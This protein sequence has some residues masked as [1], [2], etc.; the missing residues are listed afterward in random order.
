[1]CPLEGEG[2]VI[3]KRP[4]GSKHAKIFVYISAPIYHDSTFPFKVG[5]K[6][7]ITIQKPDKLI[8]ERLSKDAPKKTKR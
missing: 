3:D 6:I 2:K 4:K 7:K 8:L 5:E 1:M